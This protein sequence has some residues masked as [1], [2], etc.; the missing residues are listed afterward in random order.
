M[1]EK[2]EDTFVHSSNSSTRN[3]LWFKSCLYLQIFLSGDKITSYKKFFR[4]N[5]PT[6][7]RD[8]H[9]FLSYRNLLPLNYTIDP[10]S[11]TIHRHVANWLGRAKSE[12]QNRVRYF[13]DETWGGRQES[14]SAVPSANIDDG[15]LVRYQCRTHSIKSISTPPGEVWLG[16]FRVGGKRFPLGRKAKHERSGEWK[17]ERWIKLL[18]SQLV[19]PGGCLLF[20]C[21]L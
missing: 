11:S 21:L 1:S 3:N 18:K 2:A 7:T 9:P 13:S 10:E 15:G 4:I 6:R 16:V 12:V 20:S 8:D 14:S 17:I 19:F 5:S